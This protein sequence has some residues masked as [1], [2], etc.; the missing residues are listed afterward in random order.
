M[1]GRRVERAEVTGIIAAGTCRATVRVSTE[2]SV[3]SVPCYAASQGG[4]QRTT[5]T[6]A[7]PLSYAKLAKLRRCWAAPF[8]QVMRVG[9]QE[10]GLPNR[11]CRRWVVSTGQLND[12]GG[13]KL[14]RERATAK[15]GGGGSRLQ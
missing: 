12:D 4:G 1:F 2:G 8:L 11:S 15:A 9:L 10:T 7:R 13:G 5:T 3:L 14:R 6:A